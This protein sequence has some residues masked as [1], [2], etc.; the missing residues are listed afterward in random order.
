MKRGPALIATLASALLALAPAAPARAA[1]PEGNADASQATARAKSH[2]DAALQAYA[3]AQYLAAADAF[4]KAY[5]LLPSPSLIFS[6]AQAYRRQYYIDEEPAHLREAV[7]LYRDYLTRADQGRRRQEASDA[8]TELAPFEARARQRAAP[9]PPAQKRRTQLLITSRT[10]GALTSIDGGPPRRLPLVARVAPGEHVVVI[11]APGYFEETSKTI[12]VQSETITVNVLLRPRAA[13]LH[14]RGDEGAKVY[15][16]GQLLAR[17]P[18]GGPLALAGGS[19]TLSVAEPGHIPYATTLWLESGSRVELDV[20]LPPT[21]QRYAAFITL[22]LG[23]ASVLAAG[24]FAGLAASAHAEAKSI[25]DARKA[26]E[27]SVAQ[28]DA[29]NAA[30]DRRGAMIT[31]AAASGG[32]AAAL[33]ML[34]LGLYLFDNPDVAASGAGAPSGSGSGPPRP[35]PDTEL[36]IDA[37]GVRIRGSF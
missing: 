1:G 23:G 11:R 31:G 35:A 33:G 8:L 6:A 27:I 21:T 26:G 13:Q 34:G 30:L 25:D 20:S 16:D 28:R 4:L 9:A 7:R 3:A 36:L 24:L 22:G 17:L 2:F 10:P 19:R 29:H 12:A 15:A 32:A 5:E 37:T 14:V 18:S